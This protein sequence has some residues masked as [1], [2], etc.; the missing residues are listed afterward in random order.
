MSV[1]TR[2]LDPPEPRHCPVCEDCVL[3]EFGERDCDEASEHERCMQ[4]DD[5]DMP[6]ETSDGD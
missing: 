4:H 5:S 3:L 6:E 1:P 2:L